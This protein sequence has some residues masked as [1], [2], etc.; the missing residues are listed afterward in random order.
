VHYRF[1]YY[2]FSEQ[3]VREVFFEGMERVRVRAMMTPPRLIGHGWKPR[4]P[5]YRA[6]VA[7]SAPVR[8][9]RARIGR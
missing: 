7:R 5:G 4:R 8:R 1:D 3:A 2:R 6:R 9:T